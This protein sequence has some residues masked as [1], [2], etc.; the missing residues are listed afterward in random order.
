[1]KT[2]RFMFNN[3]T[4]TVNQAVHQGNKQKV[5]ARREQK[6]ARKNAIKEICL[7]CTKKNCN[8]NC[9]KVREYNER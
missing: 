9:K 2:P 4:G 6:I 8:G 5:S 1:M 7:N 3:T